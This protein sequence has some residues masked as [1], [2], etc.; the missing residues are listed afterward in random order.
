M[1]RRRIIPYNAKL[2]PLARKLRKNMIL[3][4]ILLWQELK[5]KQLLG[6]DFDRQIPIDNYIVDFYCKE[7]QL[8]VEIDGSS[9]TNKDNAMKDELRQQRLES[10]GIHFL[11]FDDLDVKQNIKYVLNSIHEWIV[12]NTH[13]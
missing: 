6:Y 5:G 13:P 11:R 10:L 3:A 8:V 7:L 2:H 9:H 12:A 1:N 4:E